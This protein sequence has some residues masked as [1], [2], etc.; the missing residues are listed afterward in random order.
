[1]PY[2]PLLTRGALTFALDSSQGIILSDIDASE[3]WETEVAG[4][5]VRHGGLFTHNAQETLAV[6]LRGVVRGVDLA[7]ARTRVGNFWNVLGDGTDDVLF[8]AFDDREIV[9]RPVDRSIT[10]A[11]GNGFKAGFFDVSLRSVDPFW[12]QIATSVFNASFNGN[13]EVT[14]T[15]SV[16]GQ[17]PAPFVLDI[18]G[19]GGTSI[20]DTT[21]VVQ[22]DAPGP[23]EKFR[24]G[25]VTLAAGKILRVDTQ[26]GSVTDDTGSLGVAN[27]LA[28]YFDGTP[29]LLQ[30][31]SNTLRFRQ[32]GT[33]APNV[34]YS[35]VY[36]ARFRSL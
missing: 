31:G 26:E 6:R 30:P 35:G 11:R 33:P 28:E 1:M 22:R 16:S 19:A 23:I 15:F 5:L 20:A 27:A 9:C 7:S 34:A 24:I 2:S 4:R 13:G 17:A 18:Q 12:R 25:K 29:F 32:N 10:W 3:G 36:R 14:T 21:I 8:R